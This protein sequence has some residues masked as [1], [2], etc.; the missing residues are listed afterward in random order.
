VLSFVL[1]HALDYVF[2]PWVR[3]RFRRHPVPQP[4]QAGGG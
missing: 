2:Q 1:A 3:A 4:L